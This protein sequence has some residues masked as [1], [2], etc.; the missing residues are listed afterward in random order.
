VR[1][2]LTFHRRGEATKVA[3]TTSTWTL[4][5]DDHRDHHDRPPP[6]WLP[7]AA[8]WQLASRTA[9]A[10]APVAVPHLQEI[11]SESTSQGGGGVRGAASWTRI[12][13]VT[14]TRWFRK[15]RFGAGGAGSV[16]TQ[17][18]VHGSAVSFRWS[19]GR[20]S[21]RVT[22]MRNVKNAK[23][24]LPC[25]AACSPCSCRLSCVRVAASWCGNCNCCEY[26]SQITS[27]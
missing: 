27:N 3:L 11:V 6:E 12:Q 5:A 4:R 17:I 24:V 15:F 26:S 22:G 9:A 1:S 16:T 14:D 25:W 2:L 10:T 18:S 21:I 8:P 7:L 19:V 23:I 20:A 13:S